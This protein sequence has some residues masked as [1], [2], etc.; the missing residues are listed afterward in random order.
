MLLVP[1]AMHL[2]G[3]S[4]WWL[5]RWLDRIVPNIDVEGASLRVEPS[6]RI[7]FPPVTATTAP[8]T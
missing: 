6:Q 5:P 1:S 7:G 4:V 2:L 8:E 3:A